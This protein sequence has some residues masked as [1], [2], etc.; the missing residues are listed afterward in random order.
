VGV[1]WQRFGS[2]SGAKH[3]TKDLPLES[4]T[5]EEFLEAYGLWEKYGWPQ[6]FIYRCIR[7]PERLDQIDTEQL[8]KVGDFFA[9]FDTPGAHPGI[10]RSYSCR[11]FLAILLMT[12]LGIL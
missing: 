7:S 8:K 10:Y 5:H 4:G 1:L 9:E 11:G 2:P 6:I 12:T 3:P